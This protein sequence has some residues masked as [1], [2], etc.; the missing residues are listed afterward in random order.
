MPEGTSLSRL[1]KAFSDSVEKEVM[2]VAERLGLAG[3][4]EFYEELSDSELGAGAIF[5]V[6]SDHDEP[7]A[8]VLAFSCKL[9]D[10]F[11]KAGVI[12]GEPEIVA[13]TDFKLGGKVHNYN[14]ADAK[15]EL[16]AVIEL[17][18]AKVPNSLKAAIR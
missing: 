1:R 16:I 15:T 5:R 11:T 17:E 7:S 12:D 6:G 9:L 4:V 8:M 14:L 3:D 10:Y 13:I 2:A 18:A